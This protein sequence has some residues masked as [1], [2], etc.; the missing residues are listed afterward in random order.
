MYLQRNQLPMKKVALVTGASSGIG[1][2]I[3]HALSRTGYRVALAARNELDLKKVASACEDPSATIV[4]PTD[5]RDDEQVRR[6]VDKTIDA[7]GQIDVLVNNA[8]FGTFKPVIELTAAEFDSIIAVNLRGAFLATRYTLPHMYARR[9][10]AVI[11]ISS[12]AGKHGFASGGAYCAS[13]F[14]LM[15][16]MECVFQEARRYDVRVVTI[17]PGSV[18]TA[19]FD[20]A[21]TEAPNRERILQPDDVA[22]TV[23]LA[24]SLPAR[25]LLRELD[26]RPTNPH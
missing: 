8:G 22:E 11:N 15:G 24:L 3:V 17:T 10:G 5:V 6:M 9:D 23:L 2:S 21:Q 20:Q 13:K 14:G 25:A 12:I 19:F 26:I 7:F 18:D 1:A 4:L 16:L